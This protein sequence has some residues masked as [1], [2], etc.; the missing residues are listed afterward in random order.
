VHRSVLPFKVRV[1]VRVVRVLVPFFG[2]LWSVLCFRV[3]VNDERLHRHGT[4]TRQ[5]AGSLTPVF[6]L[7]FVLGLGFTLG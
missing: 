6:G 5:K 1:Y 7:C 4:V 3:K 2:T